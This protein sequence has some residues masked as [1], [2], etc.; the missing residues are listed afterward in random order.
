M[1]RCGNIY[2][3]IYDMENLKLAHKNARKDKLFYQEVKMVDSDPE[4]YLGQIQTMLKEKIYKVSP[5][6]VSTI[7]DKGKQREL[8]KLPYFPDRI[9]QWAILLQIE[10]VFMKTFCY[11]TCASIKD[12]GIRR[13]SELT[14]KYMKDKF[15][16]SYC[17]KIDVSKFYPNIN[18]SALKGLLLRK[19]KDKNLLELLF[20]IIDST[21]GEK[22]VPIGS[23]LSQFLAN[24]YLSYF[25]HWLKETMKVKCVVRYMDDIVVFSY[26]SSYLHWLKRQM[27]IYLNDN[28]KLTIKSNWQVFPTAIRGVDFVGFRH[29][30]GYKLLRKCTCKKMKRKMLQIKKKQDSGNMIN[31]NQWCAANSYN[32][33]LNW[34]NSYRLRMKYFTPVQPSLDRYYNKVVKE[35]KVS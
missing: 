19:F 10:P 9:I 29:F 16:S 13:A 30:Y 27:D 34:C 3:K 22:G 17:L 11:H 4:F 33:W 24:F 25:D 12:R 28:L 32:G 20:Q 15:N 26:S 1:K 23:Y 31:F 5:Y 8:M 7:N 18:H 21:P 35:R 14:D 2:E 6:T